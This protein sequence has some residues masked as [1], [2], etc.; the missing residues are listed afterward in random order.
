MYYV[1]MYIY[2]VVDVYVVGSFVVI[3]ILVMVVDVSVVG[4]M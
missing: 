4:T 1:V 3:V 2:E